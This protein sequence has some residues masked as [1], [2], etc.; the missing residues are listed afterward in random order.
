MSN[1]NALTIKICIQICYSRCLT[2]AEG[3]GAA[4]MDGYVVQAGV[5]LPW[6]EEEEGKLDRFP[7]AKD[8]EWDRQPNWDWKYG[9]ERT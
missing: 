6:A 9:E 4:A 2:E 5:D 8:R 7:I 3:I 1:K